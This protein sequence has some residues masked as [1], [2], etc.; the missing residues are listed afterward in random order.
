MKFLNR[1]IFILLIITAVILSAIFY[2]LTLI[3]KTNNLINTLENA[4]TTTR[5]LFEEQK[6][7]ALSLAII[8]AQDKEIVESFLNKNREQSFEI[9]NRKI[10]LLKK[11]QN[12]QIDVQIHNEDMSTYIRSWDLSIK[13]VP[14]EEFRQGIVKVHNED[15]PFVSIELGKRL[16]IKAISPL[17]KENKVIGS[18]E[19]II[20]F[21]YLESELQQKGLQTFI[22]LE[23]KYLDIADTL[24]NN[25]KIQNFTLVNDKNKEIEALNQVDINNLKDYGYFTSK[26][27]A[28]SYFSYYS[29]DRG[30]LGYI[31][32]SSANKDGIT[33]NNSYE[34]NRPITKDGII[35]E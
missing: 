32:V 6:R 15:R 35:I 13:D 12:S 14:L 10:N 17:T 7:Y 21:E 11:L 1:T 33:L 19:V 3:N 27:K 23:N 20:G 4:M 16:N 28:F 25:I 8:L 30:K 5:Y 22:L 9:V 31:M 26:E 2:K 24:K 34:K 18:I 29:F